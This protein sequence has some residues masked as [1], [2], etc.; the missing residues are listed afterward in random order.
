MTKK[1]ATA[2][3]LELTVIERFP[4]RYIN[5]LSMPAN[6]KRFSNHIVGENSNDYLVVEAL[7][8]SI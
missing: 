3:V 2:L 7:L 1:Y 5:E 6:K 4:R 8:P